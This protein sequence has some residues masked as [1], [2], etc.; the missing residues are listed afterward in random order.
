MD[1]RKTQRTEQHAPEN[2][3]PL[4]YVGARQQ[5]VCIKAIQ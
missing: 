5:D 2:I 4:Y 3:E 1:V